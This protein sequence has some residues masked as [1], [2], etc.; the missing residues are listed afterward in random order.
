[1]VFSYIDCAVFEDAYNSHYPAEYIGGDF[2]MHELPFVVVLAL[3]R[4]DEMS[5]DA[6]SLTQ[7]VWMA[8][9]LQYVW[10]FLYGACAPT[11]TSDA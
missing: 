10:Q 1:M 6:Q 4:Y 11:P 2:T 8:A 7:Q 5:L 9:G 3:G